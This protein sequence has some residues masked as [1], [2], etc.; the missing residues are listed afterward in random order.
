MSSSLYDFPDLY[1]LVMRP[2]FSARS[3]YRSMAKGSGRSVLVLCCGAGRISNALARDDL[4]VVGLDLSAAMLERCREDAAAGETP[5]TLVQGDMRDFDL[6]GQ[7][8]DLIAIPHNSLL[9]LLSVA[10]LLACFA[11]VARHLKP[12]GRLAFDVFTPSISV[13]ARPAGQRHRIGLFQ[14]PVHGEIA[15]EEEVSYDP[16]AQVREATWFWSTAEQPDMLS[17]PMTMRLIF[18][19]EL[20]LLIEVAGF[21]MTERHG[22]FDRRPFGPQ[23]RHQVC[24]CELLT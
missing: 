21:R 13:L 10:D 11:S 17:T 24:V 1:E 2:N 23:S 9:Q 3:F 22:D 19:Q 8:F 12:K 14:H 16:A 15:L 20:P 6:E 7:R 18:P 4:A 5:I